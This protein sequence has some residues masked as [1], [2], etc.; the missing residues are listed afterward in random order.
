MHRGH[1][2]RQG[3]G[4][5]AIGTGCKGIQRNAEAWDQ[6]KARFLPCTQGSENPLRGTPVRLPSIAQRISE[7]A[8]SENVPCQAECVCAR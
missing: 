5:T 7:G 3:L 6:H 8:L 2:E 1:Q 4:D